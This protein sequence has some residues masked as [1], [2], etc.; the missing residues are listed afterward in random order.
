MKT[1]RIAGSAAIGFGILTLLSGVSALVG[2]VDMGDV[3]PVV[4]WFN[5]F[6]GI[7]Y[8]AGGIAMVLGHRLSL[9]LALAIFLAT[10]AIFLVFGWR[11]RAG[12]AFEMR[13]VWAMTLRTAFW[14]AMVWIAARKMPINA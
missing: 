7:A 6:A 3:V 10:A 9:P 5:V 11:V 1:H 8:V 2:A 4:L 12:D 14:A 13:T